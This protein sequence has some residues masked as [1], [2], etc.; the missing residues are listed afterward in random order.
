MQKDPSPHQKNRDKI[1]SK[2][3]TVEKT[4]TAEENVAVEEMVV[5]EASALKDVISSANWPTHIDVYNYLDFR[6]WIKLPWRFTP[7]SCYEEAINLLDRFVSHRNYDVSKDSK[8]GWKSLAI[9][10]QNGIATNTY[11]HTHYNEEPNYQLTEIVKVCPKT[12]KMLNFITEIKQCNRIRWMLLMP[13]AKIS[14]H[15][16]K[17]KEN[18]DVSLALNIALNM[19]DECHFWIDTKKNGD[20]E[21]YTRKIPIQEGE[22]ILL[23]NA[24]YHYVE[25]NSDQIRIH[26]IV[27]GPIRISD[28]MLLESAKNQCNIHNRK[29]LIN[30][31][32]VK[33]ALQGRPLDKQSSWFQQWDVEGLDTPFIPNDIKILLL[34]DDI[35]DKKILDEALYQYSQASLFLEPH[36]VLDYSQIDKTLSLLYEQGARFVVFVGAG[37]FLP[38][39]R[40]FLFFLLQTINTMDKKEASASAHII[41]HPNHSKGLPFFH[42]QFFILDLKS[43]NKIGR[44]EI[45]RPYSSAF[46]DFPKN[47]IKGESFHDH[48]TPK[49]LAPNPNERSL[50]YEHGIGGLGTAFISKSLKNNLTII[51][52]PMNLRTVKKFS[53]PRA[54]ICQQMLQ[55]EKEKLK[56]LKREQERIFVFNNENL[57][58]P[59]FRSIS[60]FKP[61][62]LYSVAAGLKPYALLEEIYQRTQKTPDLHFFDFSARA[63]DYQR[64]IRDC[65]SIEQFVFCLTRKLSQ[66]RKST[67]NQSSSDLK[68]ITSEK[69]HQFLET[70]FCND[71]DYFY[72]IFQSVATCFTHVNIITNPEALIEKINPDEKFM[73][74]ISNIWCTQAS[75]F[76]V[77]RK[78]LNK[79]FIDF[80]RAVGEKINMHSWVSINEGLHNG[81]FSKGT[82]NEIHGIVTCGHGSIDLAHFRQVSP[83]RYPA[84]GAVTSELDNL[85]LFT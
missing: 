58:C 7:K 43:W 53:Y 10:A 72:E 22:A 44:P 25:N 59:F 52:I 73:I 68:K 39:L 46:V 81:F 27:H 66:G 19:P 12:M 37:T 6:P 51:N 29:N 79:N 80:I 57:Y 60:Y 1:A 65:H 71:F 40:D 74:W 5:A 14:A 13:G 9:K 67:T 18:D 23:N 32:V 85:E 62:F 28:K 16:D 61:K 15:S 30:Q 24:K 11:A 76:N 70:S 48:Y 8:N 47:Y 31:I 77:G 78:N 49:F 21:R 35:E 41:D 50:E 55:V 34:K 75:F 33:K 56:I 42:E 82:G 54:G 3:M 69:F 84:Q 2:D 17:Q 64:E 83:V 36:L 63:L 4:A 26:I 20:H 45:S 38:N